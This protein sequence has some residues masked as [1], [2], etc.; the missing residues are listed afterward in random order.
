MGPTARPSTSRLQNGR[1][2]DRGFGPDLHKLGFNP[3]RD[4]VAVDIGLR[5]DHC[6]V[7]S[8]SKLDGKKFVLDN[9]GNIKPE[10]LLSRLGVGYMGKQYLDCQ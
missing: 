6:L 1:L 5:I 9:H 7:S 3:G 8:T 10:N 4:T 2:T